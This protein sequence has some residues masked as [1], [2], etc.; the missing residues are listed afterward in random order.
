MWRFRRTPV[1]D[2][3][4]G[5]PRAR[6]LLTALGA[7][8]RQTV[9]EIFLTAAGPDDHACLMEVA[10]GA[11]GVQDWI[12]EWVAAE[13]DATLPLL[14]QGCHA[15]SWAW[16]ARGARYA[17]FTREEQ[18]REFFRRLTFAEN[19]LNEVVDRDPHEVTAWTWLTL[20][21]RGRQVDPEEAAARF[22][23]V[24]KRVP[25]HL[26][27]HEQRLQYLC[28]KWFGSHQEMF[29]FA[30]ESAARASYG[31]MLPELLVVAHLEYWLS[32][33]SGEDDAYLISGP[34]RADVVTAAEHSVLH[35]AFVP[36]F[37]WPPRA[38]TFAMALTMTGEYARA[39]R[40]FDL[41]GD[42]VTEWPWSYR[43]IVGSPA[44]KFVAARREAYRNRG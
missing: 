34:V 41:I 35:T 23:E 43:T 21:A 2:P 8:D 31:S 37:G 27:A 1:I 42:R 15:V 4:Y 16:E 24:T 33:P 9:R 40:V 17:R 6:A 20:S 12:G 44:R 38:N 39:A 7:R 19:C 5:D 36:R 32:L 29:A 22:A 30:R 10:T 18:F 13:P 26:V 25:E 11:D 3:A 14:L 28:G